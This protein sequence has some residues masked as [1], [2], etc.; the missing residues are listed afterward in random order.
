MI[1][2]ENLTVALIYQEINS[3][4][5]AARSQLEDAEIAVDQGIECEKHK[6]GEKKDFVFPRCRCPGKHR[7]EL[8]RLTQVSDWLSGICR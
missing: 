6:D 3:Q 1:V 8:K 5:A 4:M 7:D 2:K